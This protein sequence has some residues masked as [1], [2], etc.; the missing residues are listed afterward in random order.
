MEHIVPEK[1]VEQLRAAMEIRISPSA[2]A[3]FTFVV[4]HSGQRSFVVAGK[5]QFWDEVQAARSSIQYPKLSFVEEWVDG[6]SASIARISELFAGVG[7]VDGVSISLEKSSTWPQ[8]PHRWNPSYTGWK[9]WHFRSDLHR[10]EGIGESALPGDPVLLK[11]EPPFLNGVHAMHEWMWKDGSAW[12]RRDDE[13]PLWAVLTILP[14]TRI[15]IARAEWSKGRLLIEMEIRHPERR[16]EV[17]VFYAGSQSKRHDIVEASS[18]VE[19]DVP[20]GSELIGIFVLDEEGGLLARKRLERSGELL[21][22]VGGVA[23][24]EQKVLSELAG[25]ENEYVEF[26][27]FVEQKDGKEAELVKTVVAFS[28]SKGGRLYVGVDDNGTPQGVSDLKKA[29]KRQ[30]DN[31]EIAIK[32]IRDRLDQLFQREVKPAPRCGFRV[33]D[34]EGRPVVVVDVKEGDQK[35]YANAQNEYFVRRGASS[36]RPEPGEMRRL[37]QGES[38]HSALWALG[39]GGIV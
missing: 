26:K 25:G 39:R 20:G 17:Q 34:K 22:D 31:V 7:V 4:R 19:L 23:T 29:A 2:G 36:M 38:N 24:D 35:P 27:P 10:F 18:V 33:H 5:I 1:L 13:S 14:D 30:D 12:K 8:E 16:Y 21:S 11:G 15:R 37:I 32:A 28:N 9:E 3:M 6:A